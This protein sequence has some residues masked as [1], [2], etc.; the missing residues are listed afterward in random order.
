[1]AGGAGEEETPAERVRLSYNDF[2]R[3]VESPDGRD[4]AMGSGAF[5]H[6]QFMPATAVGLAARTAWG[7][8]MTADQVKAALAD[9]ATGKARADE[10]MSL[11]TGDSRTALQ[12]LGIPASNTALLAMHRFGQ[13]GGASLLQAPGNMPVAQ[14]VRSVNWGPGI[15]A[16]AVIKQNKLDRFGDVNALRNGFLGGNGPAPAGTP[17]T[18]PSPIA[19]AFAQPET[20]GP[21]KDDPGPHQFKPLD[22]LPTSDL[23]AM[24]TAPAAAREKQAKARRQALFG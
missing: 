22:V 19:A 16:D 2:V 13:G 18:E 4:N 14:W 23:A 10:L 11:Y 8:G 17:A 3:S 21:L 7:R 15:S 5:S 1:M 20:S 9:P 12:R 24:F 6:Y